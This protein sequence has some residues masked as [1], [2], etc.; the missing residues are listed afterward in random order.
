ILKA[1]GKHGKHN[2]IEDHG[3]LSGISNLGT[4]VYEHFQNRQ[5][6]AFTEATASLQ[7]NQFR[8]LV[9]FSFLCRLSSFPKTTPTG[10]ELS[11]EDTKLF[12]ELSEGIKSFQSRARKKKE[13]EDGP[14]DTTVDF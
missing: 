6:R 12:K 10:I 9:P 14:E 4:Q 7:T 13:E 3:N 1:G 11:A 8:L 2:N 5:F